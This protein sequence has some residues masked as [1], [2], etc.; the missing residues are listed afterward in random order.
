MP[1][2]ALLQIHHLMA[3]RE[4]PATP[5]FLFSAFCSFFFRLRVDCLRGNS[6]I[7]GVRFALPASSH[8]HHRGLK[9]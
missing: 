8:H 9:K 3:Q 2:Q 7:S 6:N 5:L 4:I 1:I